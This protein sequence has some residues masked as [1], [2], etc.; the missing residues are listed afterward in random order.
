VRAAVAAVAL[1]PLLLSGCSDDDGGDGDDESV[2]V[3]RD[4]SAEGRGELVSAEPIDV[5]DLDGRAWKV[6]YLS[7]ATNGEP[8]EVS[9]LIAVPDSPVPAGG[10]PVLSWAHGTTGL[11]DQC[12]PSANPSSAL[13]I[14]GPI[15][16][17]G[18]VFAATDYIGLGTP[19]PHPYL[20]GDS[21]GRAVLDMADAARR[22]APADASSDVVLLGHSQ[23]GHAVLFAR[24]LAEGW[25]DDI[26]V[27]GVVAIA[28]PSE[29]SLSAAQVVGTPNQGYLMLSLFG[30]RAANPE[31]A[32]E[33]VLAPKAMELL[34]VIDT[35]CSG[36]V[37]ATYR[38]LVASDLVKV[39]PTTLPAWRDAL[40]ENDPGHVAS[41]VPLL[42]VH[43]EKDE[44]VPAA[45]S[46]RLFDRLCGAGQ[47]VER[48]TY[49]GA[50]H[51]SVV[52]FAALDMSTWLD[53][54]LAGI[55]AQSNC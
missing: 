42:I 21:E 11:A 55:D 47:P 37:L 51:G 38:S 9:G 16:A 27:R 40:E 53:A 20:V 31:L 18:W 26:D 52:L 49:P 15:L 43:G 17:K 50:D 36:E 29:P 24:E 6:R 5:P 41:D 25:E 23:G 19:G 7:T 34:P 3:D 44:L 32:L 39:D 8:V 22:F 10:R 12:A 28:P 33:D 46:R 54:R 45:H 30:L 2:G 4:T 13:V 1:I 48:R 14:A 35:R